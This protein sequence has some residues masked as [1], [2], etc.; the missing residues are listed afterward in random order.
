MSFVRKEIGMKK[1][2]HRLSLLVV[3][4]SLASPALAATDAARAAPGADR[5]FLAF[6][7]TFQAQ[8]PMAAASKKGPGG[9]VGALALCH[10]SANCW[11]GSSRYCE[12]HTN[13]ANCTGVDS[14]CP[15]QSG[16][17]SCNGSTSWCPP[18]PD[19]CPSGWCDGADACAWACHPCPYNYTCNQTYCSDDCQCRFDICSP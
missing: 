1:I 5:A 16:Y 14:S 7:A 6:L 12:D 3:L 8:T 18:C 2:L 9:G 13:P 19:P 10:A 17:V 4:V 15:G 11:D